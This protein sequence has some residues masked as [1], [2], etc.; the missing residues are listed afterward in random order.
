[1]FLWMLTKAERHVRD[2]LYKIRN[3]CINELGRNYSFLAVYSTDCFLDGV[4]YRYNTPDLIEKANARLADARERH[5]QEVADRSAKVQQEAQAQKQLDARKAKY[6]PLYEALEERVKAV[7]GE[8][9][10]EGYYSNR[11]CFMMPLLDKFGC[12][13][14]EPRYEEIDYLRFYAYLIDLEKATEHY[15]QQVNADQQRTS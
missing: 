9:K 12:V 7:G 11:C 1:M 10:P 2:E 5:A 6:R 4:H 14:M 13:Q 8:L 15:R 3:A